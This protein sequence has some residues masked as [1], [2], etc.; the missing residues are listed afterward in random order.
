MTTPTGNPELIK[1]GHV[2]GL[3]AEQLA[4]LDGLA[5]V[6]AQDLRT[7]RRQIGEAL[8]RADK[9]HFAKVAALSKAVPTA[10][11]A[12]LTEHALP[13]LLAARTAELLEPQRAGDLVK[14]LPDSYVAD[15]AVAMDPARSPEVIAGI[16]AERVAR[17]AAE[18]ARRGEWVVIGG[19]VAQVSHEGLAASVRAFDGEQLLRISFV[20]DEPSRLDEIAAALTDAQLDQLLAA[21]AERDLWTELA[22]LLANVGEPALERLRPRLAAAPEAVRER[23]RQAGTP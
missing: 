12:K 11:A 7:L 14:R 23:I 15:V 10:V 9:Q 4:A 8:F 1:L 22:A 6:P 3:A 19:F 5:D 17:V 13:P 20:L 21:A 2:L 18:L 16:P